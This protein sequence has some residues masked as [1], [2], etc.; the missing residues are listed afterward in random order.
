M[1]TTRSYLLGLTLLLIIPVVA[2]AGPTLAEKVTQRL[3]ELR[4]RGYHLVPVKDPAVTNVIGDELIAVRFMHWPLSFPAP[5]PLKGNALFTQ[6]SGGTL[7]A[8][9]D[10]YAL[11]S[12]F[13]Q[14]LAPVKGESAAKDALRAWLKLSEEFFQDGY[15]SFALA[16]NS[17]KVF[18]ASNGLS[19][20]GEDPVKPG[21]GDRGALTGNLVFDS[22]GKL[23]H[24]RTKSTLRA[25]VRPICQA[26]KLLDRDTT[27]RRMAER[28]LLVLGTDAKPYLDYI[29]PELSPALRRAADK[30]WA[31]IVEEN[32]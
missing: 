11:E 17:F 22:S 24:G 13:R 6:S 7:I 26:K 14:K 25:G 15:Y 31:R 8:L 1:R 29:R 23:L 2:S 9:T 27:V 32:R 21:H 3:N 28:D 4:A 18:F 19:V 10:T 20:V 12:F 30:L 16:E 5:K